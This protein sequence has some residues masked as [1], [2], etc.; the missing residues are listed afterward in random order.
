MITIVDYDMGNLRSVAK[1]FEHLGHPAQVAS[2]PDVVRKAERLVVPGVGAFRDAIGTLRERGLDK[3]ILEQA[4]TGRPL[5]GICLGMQLFF[6]KSEEYGE[7]TGL[8]LFRGEVVRFPA[9][10]DAG[11]V[12]LKVPHMGWN[13]VEGHGELGKHLDGKYVYFVHSYYCAPANPQEVAGMTEY[14]IKFC[15]AAARDNIWA[16]QFHPEKSAEAG[17]ALLD[18]FANR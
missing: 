13:T 12:E 11:G 5:L 3:A 16:A 7:H 4:S 14:G 15:S 18:A 17:M 9:M 10:K 6:E 2:D 1:A 8:G